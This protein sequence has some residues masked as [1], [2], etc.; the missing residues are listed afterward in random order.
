MSALQ[1]TPEP[2]SPSTSRQGTKPP[3]VLACALCQQ[4]KV[5]CDRKFPCANCLKSGVECVPATTGHRERKRRFAERQLLDRIRTYEDLLRENNVE[6]KPLHKNQ[7][8]QEEEAT[9]SFHLDNNV[10]EAVV[11]D[12]VK[13]GKERMPKYGRFKHLIAHDLYIIPETFGMP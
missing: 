2:N 4:R 12:R 8:Q 11:V 13:S 9:A 10:P 5:R 7:E 3:R 6:F 1:L